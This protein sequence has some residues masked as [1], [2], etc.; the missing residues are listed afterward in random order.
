MKMTKKTALLTMGL[1]GFILAGTV[2]AFGGHHHNPEERA[3]YMVE[4]I[5]KKLSL[6]NE[7]KNKLTVLK[8]SML[9]LRSDI[10]QDKAV[11]KQDLLSSVSGT[12]L[13]E[14]VILGH[15]EQ[16]A[17]TLHTRAPEF[18]AALGEFY[19]SLDANQQEKVRTK[20]NKFV[21]R[22]QHHDYDDLDD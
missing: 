8:D 12:T 21:Q 14:A 6:N 5:T 13:D 17:E 9:T 4:K 7:Q 18:V 15:I 20:I 19:N 22:M 11:L 1:L 2:F 3:T 16:K 10:K